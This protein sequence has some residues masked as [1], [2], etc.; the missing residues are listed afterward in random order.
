MIF[1]RRHKDFLVEKFK[2][3]SHEIDDDYFKDPQLTELKFFDKEG[4]ELTALEER[5]AKFNGLSFTDRAFGHRAIGI[6][7]YE[8]HHFPSPLIR[9]D[10][11]FV[12]FRPPFIGQARKQILDHVDKIPLLHKLLRITTK[13]GYDLALEIVDGEFITELLHIEKDY[14]YLHHFLE[15]II[16]A[17]G[18]LEGM[19]WDRAIEQVKTITPLIQHMP[20]DD[21]SDLKARL[22][23]FNRTYETIKTV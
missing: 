18:Q 10:H 11:S 22:L 20:S 1:H 23:G 13:V 15:G 12:C 8:S 19:L 16:T 2:P 21:Q 17:Q 5:Y 6:E 7:W 4:F 9:V 14:H 3:Y